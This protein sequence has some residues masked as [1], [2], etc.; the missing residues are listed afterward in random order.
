MKQLIKY[1]ITA[2]LLGGAS[3]TFAYDGFAVDTV[4]LRAGPDVDY[5]VVTTIPAG[6]PLSI[7]GCTDAWE[8]CDVIFADARGWVA[9][10]YIQYDYNDRPVLLAGYGAA[11]GIPIVSFVIADYWGHYY[12]G[13]S[14]WGQ[15]DRW[16]ARPY[17]HHSAPVFRGQV[18]D[19]GHERGYAHG[20]TYGNR[21]YAA[22]GSEVHSEYRG[23]PQVV[24]APAHDYHPQGGQSNHGGVNPAYHG[25]AQGRQAPA[26][27]YAPA[28][29]PA[30][31]VHNAP[32]QQAQPQQHNDKHPSNSKHEDDHKHEH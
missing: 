32:Q 29:H 14:F 9:G 16:Y 2:L 21:G 17:V 3:S 25:N 28:A 6:A 20:S 5:P 8:W 27:G 15:R 24:H 23:T 1:S 4:N 10:N 30:P 31:Q 13:R 26:Q 12:R 18:H 11:I 22:H 7:Q 19:W